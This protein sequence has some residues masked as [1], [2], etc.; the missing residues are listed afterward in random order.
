MGNK[1]QV[2]V[3]YITFTLQKDRRNLKHL[4]TLF[5]S[6]RF[7]QKEKKLTA[8]WSIHPIALAVNIHSQLSLR[9]SVL[10][11]KRGLTDENLLRKL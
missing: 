6:S 10:H 11:K 3:V 5:Q 1:Y 2:A 8:L 4:R 9:F 7:S